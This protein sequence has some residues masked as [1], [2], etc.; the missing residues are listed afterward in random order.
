MYAVASFRADAQAQIAGLLASEKAVKSTAEISNEITTDRFCEVKRVDRARRN[1]T[2]EIAG[3]SF[4]V[5]F[6]A[7]FAA[8]FSKALAAYESGYLQLTVRASVDD[9]SGDI[10]SISRVVFAQFVETDESLFDITDD[11]STARMKVHVEPAAKRLSIKPRDVERTSTESPQDTILDAKSSVPDSAPEGVGMAEESTDINQVFHGLVEQ[12]HRETGGWSNPHK[13]LA[14][15][16]YRA[17]IA[18]GWAVVPL[19]IADL[20]DNPDPDFWGPALREITGETVTV[21]PDDV[22]R[23]DEIAKAWVALA[24]AKGWRT[25]GQGG[26]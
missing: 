24:E 9:T 16:C 11:G 19:I 12:W 25:P 5:K 18:M 14:H 3:S 8:E 21:A 2:V 13:I 23:L 7:E 4:Y 22:G 10:L 15:P 17:I 6:A 1:A 20:A 26:V